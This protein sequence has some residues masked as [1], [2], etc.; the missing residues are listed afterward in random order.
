MNPSSKFALWTL[1]ANL[2]L[3]SWFMSKAWLFIDLKEQGVVVETLAGVGNPLNSA[4]WQSMY[5]VSNIMCLMWILHGKQSRDPRHVPKFEL[6][7]SGITFGSHLI[8]LLV[9]YAP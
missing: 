3:A 1:I 2:A 8:D 5:I 9:R 6:A 7:V 4:F